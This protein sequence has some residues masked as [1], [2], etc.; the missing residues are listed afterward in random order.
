VRCSKAI[1]K[2]YGP[3]TLVLFAR[4][5][6]SACGRA[7]ASVGP[8]YCATGQKLYLDTAFFDEL[9]RRFRVP[10]DFAEAYVIAHEVGHP[11][12]NVTGVMQ[13]FDSQSRRLDERGR[14]AMWVRL[15]LQADCYAGVW[16]SF[17]QQR[18]K[19]RPATSRRDSPPLPQSATT[20]SGK[21]RRAM[22]CRIR[23]PMIRPPS[24]STGSR[25]GLRRAT[26]T[27]A[28]P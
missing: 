11:V 12:Q 14:D 16:G 5:F 9:A 10:G 15:E 3:P 28:T 25:S 19:P 22:S 13:R 7:S 23:S 6:P 17:A 8:F 1:G 26:C 20:A 21:E 4:A 24:V 18:G 27:G 2:R